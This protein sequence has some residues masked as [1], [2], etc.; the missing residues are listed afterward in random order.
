MST[1]T[2]PAQTLGVIGDAGGQLRSG[3]AHRFAANDNAANIGAAGE[4][5]TAAVLTD[6]AGS[7]LIAHDLKI[8]LRGV[9]ANVDHAVASGDRLLLIDSKVWEPGTYWSLGATTRRGM[10]PIAPPVGKS[11]TIALNAY[12]GMGSKQGFEVVDPITAVW[13]SRPGAGVKVSRLRVPCGRAVAGTE[14]PR[15]LARF[16]TG[17]ASPALA[18]ALHSMLTN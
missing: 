2:Y 8:P 3:G 9:K 6:F 17:P 11:M 15:L 10:R 16:A 13:S 12:R 1:P 18:R 7:A 4:R 14:L 5:R